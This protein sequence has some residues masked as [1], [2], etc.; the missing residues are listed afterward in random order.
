MKNCL[1]IHSN[2]SNKTGNKHEHRNLRSSLDSRSNNSK[3]GKR[4]CSPWVA[5]EI[6]IPEMLVNARNIQT[7]QTGLDNRNKR[8]EKSAL[9]GR[10]YSDGIINS[11]ATNK[12]RPVARASR[13]IRK[14]GRL[15]NIWPRR[16]CLSAGLRFLGGCN[17][18]SAI[19]FSLTHDAN[20]EEITR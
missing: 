4:L 18:R 6:N 13:S 20:S 10:I 9:I 19:T 11:R 8:F 16:V 2:I 15:H 1:A 12:S 7:K 5:I 17:S 3:P 14:H